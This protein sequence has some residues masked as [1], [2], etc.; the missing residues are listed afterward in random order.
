MATYHSRRI[1]FWQVECYLRGGWAIS[2]V[3]FGTNPTEW[4]EALETLLWPYAEKR[5]S[6]G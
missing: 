6:C 1:W 3:P 2:R 5:G 4:L